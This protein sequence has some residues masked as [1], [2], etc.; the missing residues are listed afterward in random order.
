MERAHLHA[1]AAP[2][3]QASVDERLTP[4]AARRTAR[5]RIE[6]DA[7]APYLGDALLAA[8]ADRSIDGYRLARF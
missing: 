1:Q 5:T 6:A 4:A 7:R 2:V 8:R 3:A